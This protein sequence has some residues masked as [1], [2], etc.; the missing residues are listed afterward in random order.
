MSDTE[1]SYYEIAL[2]N[3]QVLF[4]F[5]ILLVCVLLAFV[6][7]IWV[8][9]TALADEPPGPP[10][11]QRTASVGDEEGDS[12]RFFDSRSTAGGEASDVSPQLGGGNGPARPTPDVQQVRPVES[13]PE[14]S[15]RARDVAPTPAPTQAPTPRPTPERPRSTPTPEPTAEPQRTSAPVADPPPV[16]D[17]PVIQVLSSADES[18]AN[19]LTRRLKNAGYRAFI[20]PVEVDGRTMYRVRVG[21]YGQES[22]ASREADVLRRTFR[23]D[24]WI[25]TN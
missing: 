11:L 5:G 4:A 16:A 24:T 9:Q 3:G 19:Q 20:S 15:A 25:T 7:G 22:E 21:P 8:A 6:S 13:Q 17:L 23:V 10:Q 2:T 14:P 12:Y 18:Q 1:R